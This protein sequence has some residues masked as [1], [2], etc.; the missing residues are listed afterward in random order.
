MDASQYANLGL[1]STAKEKEQVRSNSHYIY[2][3]IKEIDEALGDSFL[4]HQD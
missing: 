3:K 2:Q 1:D 4:K